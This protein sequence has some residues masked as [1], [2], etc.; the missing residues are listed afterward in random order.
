MDQQNHRT[1][2]A[3]PEGQEVRQDNLLED[4][5]DEMYPVV[6]GV[7]MVLIGCEPD[8]P[9]CHGESAPALMAVAFERT[10]IQN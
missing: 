4:L 8:C 1:R 9:E 10:V 5:R 7:E 2:D 3:Q 6:E